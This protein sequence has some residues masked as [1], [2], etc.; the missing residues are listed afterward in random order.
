[1]AVDAAADRQND[2]PQWRS[3]ATW[4]CA[5]AFFFY[6]FVVR[7]SPSV[8]TN[9]LMKDLGITAC[10]YG[11]LISV[12]YLSYSSVQLFVGLTLDRLGVRYPL[13]VASTLLFTGCLIFST[14]SDLTMLKFAR[15][16]IGVGSALGFLSCVKTAS[17]WFTSERLGLMIG[18]SVLIG[19]AGGTSG[20]YPMAYLVKHLGWR[21]SMLVLAAIAAVI[22][23]I[24]LFMARDRA[25]PVGHSLVEE[26]AN[27]T[28]VESLKILL[29]NRQ[30][31]LYALFGALMYIPMSVFVDAWGIKFLMVLYDVESPEASACVSITYIGIAASGPLLA[32]LADHWRSYKKLMFLGSLISLLGYLIAIYVHLPSLYYTYPLFFLTGFALGAQFFAFASICELNPRQV[33]G[34]A[35]GLQ[36]MACMYGSGGAVYLI[37]R[38]LDYLSHGKMDDVVSRYSIADFH[39]ALMMVPISILLACI[40]ILFVRE[41]YPQE[42]TT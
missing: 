3:W 6:Q 41:A 25:K 38:I 31:Y 8:F 5:A 24:T 16:I 26:K 19:M 15:F 21:E 33:S 30:T 36:N 14:S 37:G 13:V 34:T 12:Y 18:M 7:V 23:I 1:M 27:L 10:D 29:S 22:G 35:S 2:Y 20:G 32:L 4:G 39:T 9:D 28:I 17:M 11:A 40:V 42:E